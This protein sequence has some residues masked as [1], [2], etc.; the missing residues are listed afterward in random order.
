MM[1][2]SGL[3]SQL[4]YTQWE[5]HPPIPICG[6]WL[7]A[8]MSNLHIRVIQVEIRKKRKSENLGDSH[9]VRGWRS[10]LAILCSYLVWLILSGYPL[11]LS[12]LAILS[13]YPV[14]RSSLEPNPGKRNSWNRGPN[15][16]K[17]FTDKSATPSRVGSWIR[18]TELN[19]TDRDAPGH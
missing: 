2:K 13:G 12:C 19:W 18:T 7:W 11:W 3:F 17:D 1:S 16:L 15:W 10:F 8:Q 4:E 6:W 9:T 5:P 14:W